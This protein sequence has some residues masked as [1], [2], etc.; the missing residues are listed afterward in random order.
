[1]KDQ[2][3]M[4]I[5]TY[6]DVLDAHERIKPYIHRTPV[7]TSEYLNELTGAKLFSLLPGVVEQFKKT[8]EGNPGSICQCNG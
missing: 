5:P 1:M 3:E 4:Y 2:S 6:Q 7:M 8:F